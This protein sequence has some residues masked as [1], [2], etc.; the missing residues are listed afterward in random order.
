[1][2]FEYLC[3]PE[4]GVLADGTAF[5]TY[6]VQCVGHTRQRTVPIMRFH[7]VSVDVAFTERLCRMC[8]QAQIE[9]CHFLDIV[10]DGLP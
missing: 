4:T 6:A 1:M 5:Q 3:I 8:T 10:Y 2:R 7:D 9:P